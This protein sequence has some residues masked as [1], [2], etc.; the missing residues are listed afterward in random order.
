MSFERFEIS[1]IERVPEQTGVYA[2]YLRPFIAESDVRDVMS[3][4]DLQS[5][6][7]LDLRVDAVREFLSDHVFSSFL[8]TPYEVTFGGPL[9]ARYKGSAG[10]TPTISDS[11]LHRIA[12]DPEQLRTV[13]TII[14][15]QMVPVFTSPIY[16]G[17]AKS[18]RQ[19]LGSHKK[20]L[21]QARDSLAQKQGFSCEHPDDEVHRRD[22]QFAT[23]V[24]YDRK[25][26]PLDLLVY[27]APLPSG[28]RVDALNAENILNR[29]CFPIC[30]RN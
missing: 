19:R 14:R 22:H 21:L 15:T 28:D 29:I 10:H 1:R 11:L 20:L 4:L 23:E 13:C 9:K 16:I 12:C 2:W 6:L 5:G 17:V 8:D 30:G 27:C 3:A 24:V 18:L 7:P 25:I 26:S